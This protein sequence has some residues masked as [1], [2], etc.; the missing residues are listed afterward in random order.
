MRVRLLASLI[1]L[2][3]GVWLSTEAA[4]IQSQARSTTVI[5]AGR[6]IDGT[7]TTVRTNATIVITGD[8]ITS[9]QDGFQPPPANARVIDLRTSTVMPG[10]IDSHTHITGE[11]TGNAIVRAATQTPLDDAVRATAYAKRTLE[12]GFTTIRNLGADGGA[13]R[14]VTAQPVGHVR[15]GRVRHRRGWGHAR[16]RRS[17]R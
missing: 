7:S 10:F 13:D 15:A 11:G 8:R 2:S 12:A 14:S 1:V 9:V 4:A 17:Q 16:E 6:L 3:A 5:H